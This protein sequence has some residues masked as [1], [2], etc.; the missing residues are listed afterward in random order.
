MMD[1]YVYSLEHK[2]DLLPCLTN[3]KKFINSVKEFFFPNFF[4]CQNEANNPLEEARDVLKI[5]IDKVFKLTNDNRDVDSLVEKIMNSIVELIPV[6]KSDLK[7]FYE[8]DPAAED[9]VE[10][11]ITYPGFKALVT[12]RVAHI[13][14][15]NQIRYLPRMLSEIA[16]SQTGIDIHPGATI[17]QSFFIDHGTGIVIGET[18]I[19]G[20]NVRIYQGV[21]VGALSLENGHALKGI[22]RHPTIGNNVIIYANASILGGE[23]II[24]DNTIIGGNVFI[25][26]SVP[27]NHMVAFN[28]SDKLIV[29][30]R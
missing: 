5:E 19:I 25:T 30:K 9:Y 8:G 27:D 14:Y 1:K 13:L 26:K 21:T 11:I 29:K 12:Y 3:I 7:S 2:T 28:N 4:T 18:S 6:I 15:Q 20:D 17:G 16:H 10:I 24:G 22:K 23:T